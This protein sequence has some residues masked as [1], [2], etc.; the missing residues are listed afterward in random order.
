MFLDFPFVPEDQ[1]PDS[2]SWHPHPSQPLSSILAGR[3]PPQHHDVKF[4]LTHKINFP[5]LPTQKRKS[6]YQQ[7]QKMGDKYMV[8]D[9]NIVNPDTM[10]AN[11]VV[12]GIDAVMLPKF[13]S[14]RLSNK[15]SILRKETT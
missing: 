3:L 1:A 8:N 2:L 7:F 13:A 9:A 4:N 11:D 10:A 12:R 5:I 6:C 14:Q 15:A